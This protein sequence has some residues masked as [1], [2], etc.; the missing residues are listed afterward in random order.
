MFYLRDMDS[1]KILCEIKTP[2]FTSLSERQVV[3]QG[4]HGGEQSALQLED[5]QGLVRWS[6]EI[7][8]MF[9]FKLNPTQKPKLEK[10][11]FEFKGICY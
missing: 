10:K 3:P 1:Q 4:E 8:L 2:R 7:V 5:S 9:I 6:C 11:N